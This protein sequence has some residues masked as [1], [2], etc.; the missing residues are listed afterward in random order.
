M[1]GSSGGAWTGRPGAAALVRAVAVVAPIAVSVAVTWRVS[2]WLPS[3]EAMVARAGLWLALSAL[4]TA[5]VFV[6]ER[7]ARRLLPLAALLKLSLAFPDQAPSRFRTALRT[8]TVRQLEQRVAEIKAHGF[9]EDE[10]RAAEQLLELIAAL[11]AHDRLTRGHAERVRAYSRMIGEELKLSDDELD[12]LHWAG[13]LHDVGKLFVPSEVLN[14]SGRLTDEEFEIIK[15]HPGWGAELCEPLRGWLGEWV[16][17][18]GQHHERWDGRGYPAGLAGADIARAA[19]IVSV[20]DVFDVITS[21]RS[22]KEPQSATAGRAELAACAGTQFDPE[23]VRAF[24]NVGLGRLRLVMGP[25]SWAAQL[26]VISRMPV[27]PAV[28]AVGGALA[29]AAAVVLGGLVHDPAPADAQPVPFE[30]VATTTAT[31]TTPTADPEPETTPEPAPEPRAV[32]AAT[33]GVPA[34]DQ[35]VPAPDLAPQDAA[36]EPTETTPP[37]AP[38]AA[39]DVVHTAEDTP[40]LIPVLANDTAGVTLGDADQPAHG[41]VERLDDVI[42]FVPDADQVGTAT[43]AYEVQDAAGARAAASVTVVIDP[44]NDA[45][46][47]APHDVS[48]A[49][50]GGPQVV[51]GAATNLSAGPLDEQG[52]AV[53]FVATAADPSLFTAGP[54][55][56]PTGALHVTPAPGVTGTTTVTVHAVDSG[57]TGDGGVDTSAAHAF[58][59]TITPTPDAPVTADDATTVAEDGTVVIAVLG[60]DSDPDGEAL[61]VTSASSADG[62]ASTDGTTVTYLPAPDA[63]GVHTLTYTVDDGTGRSDIATV[64]IAVTAVNDAPTFVPGADVTVAE[65]AGPA[66]VAGWATAISAGPADEAGQSVAFTAVAADETLFEAAPAIDA[67]GTLT[68]TSVANASGTTT[69]A[70]QLADDAGGTDTSAVHVLTVTVTPTADAPVAGDDAYATTDDVPLVVPAPGVLA[71]DG[72]EDGDTLT[73]AVTV[74]PTSGVLA[75]QADGS[76]TYTP[77][78]G[79]SGTDTFTDVASDGGPGDTAVVTIQVSATMTQSTWYLGNGGASADDWDLLAAPPGGLGAEADTDGDGNPGVTVDQSKLNLG[80]TDG[81]EYQEWGF[82]TSTPMVLDGPAALHLWSTSDGFHGERPADYSVWLQ[83]CAADGTGCVTVASTI[84]VHVNLWNEG[85]DGWVY[86]EIGLG[87]VSHTVA[88]GRRLQVRVMFDHHPVWIAT[89]AARPSALVLTQPG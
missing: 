78:L 9:D 75:M 58:T 51:A 59:V 30:A 73:A 54:V 17:A 84:A 14:K 6:V 72:D 46:S 22:Y 16:D 83:D 35:T 88:A 24:L 71:N 20:A 87:D 74:A 28:G 85:V 36:T 43:F 44:V 31:P 89:S 40:V 60:N 64:T 26:P 19:R 1:Q 68:F 81:D 25:I 77:T 65:D 61:A 70:V 57:G 34:P 80:S 39:D 10:A 79:F 47:F 42:R 41:T 63:N 8:G 69:V 15:G 52:Q 13:L 53:A 48:V 3:A 12:K 86:R 7:V 56:D 62:A 49:E 32:P 23:M 33:E 38:E 4:A 66:M 2:R 37:A 18:V 5:I 76:F 45:P 67:A 55:V 29:T 11:S 82:V 50:D 21:A 27:G